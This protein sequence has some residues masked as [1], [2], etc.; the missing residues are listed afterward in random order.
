MFI[1]EG[2]GADLDKRTLLGE[3]GGDER[4]VEEPHE[5]E[6]LE[7]RTTV[8]LH[9]QESAADCPTEPISILLK[10]FFPVLPMISSDAFCSCAR[11]H[12]RIAK[13]FVPP[14]KSTL[15]KVQFFLF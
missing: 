2:F 12:S 4:I 10:A 9:E 1:G 5:S 3:V 11:S 6:G 13:A 8:T 14:R 15:S 7:G